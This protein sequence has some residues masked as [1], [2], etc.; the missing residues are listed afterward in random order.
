MS[1]HPLSR[2]ES[3]VASSALLATAAVPE[4]AES[5]QPIATGNALRAEVADAAI[6][7]ATWV[8]AQYTDIRIN[9]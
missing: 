6:S 5:F 3:L 1:L 7:R 8:G 2:R 4:S 9:R